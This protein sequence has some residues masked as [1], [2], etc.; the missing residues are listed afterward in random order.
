M[1]PVCCQRM[2]T[3]STRT[4]CQ[5]TENGFCVM[6]LLWLLTEIHLWRMIQGERFEANSIMNQCIKLSFL[7]MGCACW[8]SWVKCYWNEGEGWEDGRQKDPD[9]NL[10]TSKIS[11]VL[12]GDCLLKKQTN[13]IPTNK[14]PK[15]T[16]KQNPSLAFGT[17]DVTGGLGNGQINVLLTQVCSMSAA[18]RAINVLW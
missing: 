15:P 14:Q 10:N 13:K 1:A 2:K 17:S 11:D 12:I 6:V 16:T 9:I 3:A 5:C 8:L 18:D 7:S 4:C